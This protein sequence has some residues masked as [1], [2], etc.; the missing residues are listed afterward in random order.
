MVTEVPVFLETQTK[1]SLAQFNEQLQQHNLTFVEPYEAMFLDKEDCRYGFC[2]NVEGENQQDILGKL[3][4]IIVLK[5][6][7]IDFASI[8][9]CGQGIHCCF[10]VLKM[11]LN[12][13]MAMVIGYINDTDFSAYI[14]KRSDEI[15]YF[16]AFLD[17][18]ELKKLETAKQAKKIEE[19]KEYAKYLLEYLDAGSIDFMQ[20][21]Y[22]PL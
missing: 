18:Q 8:K 19:W 21:G 6:G 2:F 12:A 5:L 22:Y 9:F 3:Q 4:Q 16:M 17:P 13:L 10:A 20:V 15:S 7:K 11:P 14:M 1:M